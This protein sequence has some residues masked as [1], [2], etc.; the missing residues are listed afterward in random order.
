MNRLH[1]MASRI[2]EG[3]A[4]CIGGRK[5]EAVEDICPVRSAGRTND[6][7]DRR[8]SFLG[9]A[10][11]PSGRKCVCGCKAFRNRAQVKAVHFRECRRQ[12][13]SSGRGRENHSSDG[14]V[15]FIRKRTGLIE[16][17]FLT[18]AS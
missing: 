15:V 9:C 3:E 11:I 12:S 7:A 18:L 16:N 8:P 2:V 10:E 17:S 4:V 13:E 14:R 6:R 5:T 1:T